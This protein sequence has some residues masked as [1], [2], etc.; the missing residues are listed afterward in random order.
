M[1]AIAS[2]ASWGA[3][4]RDGVGTRIVGALEKYLHHSVTTHLPETATVEQE[5]AEMRKIEQIGQ[6][7]FGAGISYTFLV[8]PSGRIYQG[9]SVHRISYHSGGGNKASGPSVGR[10]TGG[11]GI[12]LAGNYEGRPLGK[13]AKTAIASLLRHGVAAGWWRDAALTEAHRDF[14]GTACPGSGA[15]AA[16]DAINAEARSGSTPTPTPT[17]QEDEMD[18]LFFSYDKNGT[19]H[20]FGT[21][22]PAHYI[23]VRNEAAYIKGREQQGRTV[24]WWDNIANDKIVEDAWIFGEFLGTDT[25][26]PRGA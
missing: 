2:R 5:R 1:V 3:R 19:K 10:N 11:V 13:K 15:Y 4:H 7:R 12:C 24:K 14:K 21:V 20:I 25:L 18:L 9:A 8:F 16:F 22:G 17:P 23:H 26:R 6:D